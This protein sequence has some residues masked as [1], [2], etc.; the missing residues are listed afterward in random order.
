V[1]AGNDFLKYVSSS[2]TLW[3]TWYVDRK[4]SVIKFDK[5]HIT[6]VFIIRGN[7]VHW[8]FNIPQIQT[9]WL[10]Y[11]PDTKSRLPTQS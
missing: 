7:M 6:D 1:I 9:N 4:S 8:L 5:T 3:L 2:V 11:W 10:K